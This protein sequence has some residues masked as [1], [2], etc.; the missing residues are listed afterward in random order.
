MADKFP[1]GQLC[2]DDEGALAMR[3]GIKDKTIILDF[4]KPVTWMGLDK[5]SAINMANLLLE[6]AKQL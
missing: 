4:G 5:Q 6:K 1:R 3:I 2:N